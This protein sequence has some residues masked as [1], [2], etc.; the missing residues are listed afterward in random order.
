MLNQTRIGVGSITFHRRGPIRGQH[1]VFI[2]LKSINLYTLLL[3][4]IILSNSSFH[5]LE[6]IMLVS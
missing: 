2:M 3:S 6:K 4:I 5:F 1:Y